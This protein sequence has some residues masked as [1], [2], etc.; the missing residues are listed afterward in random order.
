VFPFEVEERLLD[1]REV[2][3]RLEPPEDLRVA[4]ERLDEELLEGL[5]RAGARDEL[6]V[7]EE[8]LVLRLLLRVADEELVLRLLLRVADERLAVFREALLTDERSLFASVRAAPRVALLRVTLRLLSAVVAAGLLL[9]LA[10]R[11]L[12]REPVR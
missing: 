9:R 7:A 3:A 6:R 10:E 1:P 4:D 8:R 11:V 12:V 2:F 5:A